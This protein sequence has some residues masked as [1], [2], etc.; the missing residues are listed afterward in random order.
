MRATLARWLRQLADLIDPPQHT[1]PAL[2]KEAGNLCFMQEVC[3]PGRS[4]EAKR[5]QVY[6]Q[7]LKQFPDR[8]KRAVAKA[9]E[10]VL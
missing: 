3:W 1:D 10:A 6:S 5:H 9:I 4:G 2:L 8:N 7:L